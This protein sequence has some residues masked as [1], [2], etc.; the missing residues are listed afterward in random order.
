M[1]Q[2]YINFLLWF[3]TPVVHID[4]E[5]SDVAGVTLVT[6]IVSK[7]LFG[8]SYILKESRYGWAEIREP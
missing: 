6:E 2:W 4:T 5:T 3:K 1:R 8:K 7:T